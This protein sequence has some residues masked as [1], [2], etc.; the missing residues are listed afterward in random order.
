M[1]SIKKFISVKKLK[2]Y[3]LLILL[4]L[5]LGLWFYFLIP[6]KLFIVP[7]STI[8]YSKDKELMGA[9][10]ARDGQ[11]RFP[12]PDSIPYKFKQSLI[13]FEDEWFYRHPGVNPI[14]LIKALYSDIKARKII[15]GGS[16]LT[17]QLARIARHN[18]KRN[19]YQKIME[20]FWAL[21]LETRYNKEDILKLYAA[22]APF[23]GNVVGLE[24]ASWRYF[25]RSP[26]KLSW[27][28]A[29]TLAVLPN[30]PALIYPGKNH[31]YLLKKR[32]HL[33][34]KL[35]QSKIIDSMTCVL[36]KEEA[37][38][39]KPKK[40]PQKA[41]HLLEKTI[42]EGHT[43]KKLITT[44]DEN[45][46]N[47]VEQIASRHHNFLSGNHI[48]NLGILVMNTQ[49]GE[50]LSYIGNLNNPKVPN[51]QVDMVQATRSTG[52][53][54]KPFLYAW[55]L[56]DAV[57]LPRMLLSDIPTQIAGYHP[58]NFDRKY[59]GAVPADIALAK[60]LN[61]PAVRLLRKY[62]L[63]K[64]Y[65]H[66]KKTEI[67]TINKSP[68]YYGL[69][70]ILGGAEVNLWQLTASYA[71]MGRVLYHYNHGGKYS[72]NYYFSAHY[73]P[74]KNKKIIFEKSD[75]FGAG[76]IWFVFDALSKKDR[77]VEGEDWN[78]YRSSR[79]IAWKTG[80]SFGH[81]DAWCIG[82]TPQYTIG[83]WVGN[84]TGEG[85]PGLTGTQVAA[86]LMFDVFKLLPQGKWFE[87]PLE[88]ITQT[89]I[90]EESGYLAG[91]NC[92]KSTLEY[93]P[94]TGIRAKV[95]PYCK[96]I[97]LNQEGTKQV[98][99][100]CY[101]VEKIKN[102]SRFILP[103]IQAYY[104]KTFHP[105]YQSLPPWEN[106]CLNNQQK[107]LAMIY[108]KNGIEIFLPKDFNQNQQKLVMQA[109]DNNPDATIYW[110]LDHQYIGK[111]H[112]VH[113]LKKYIPPGKHHLT[114]LDD[115]GKSIDIY[116]KI[117]R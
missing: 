11:W 77:P 26:E 100:S 21:R 88:D 34:D 59:S 110:H 42:K 55:S 83:V 4:M 90:C 117:V 79:K 7:Y 66:L 116:F 93:I 50:V 5:A 38:P 16:T 89:P 37:L 54:L 9:K 53:T 51:Y 101:P 97:H 109:V 43:G 3:R 73:L 58:E 32:N 49:T 22:H 104:Y 111:T 57:I 28:E 108:P 72:E 99:S 40:L 105:E 13:S 30:A 95:C 52:S 102:V 74:N 71:D 29:A 96:I 85:R 14:S 94:K 33:L 78:I 17:M 35:Y 27:G 114:I 80:T 31:H 113:K 67:H 12:P 2:K 46:Q 75:L 62:G 92:Q 68:D 41:P 25:G 20:I 70:L 45:L 24:A 47:Q 1:I 48:N 63:T 91:P 36:A 115:T 107:N 86:P 65:D 106:H 10:I 84:A 81:R 6:Q 44:L 98:N 69:T 61:V 15:R 103:P 76:P 82:V 56:K 23:G 19:L 8:I 39:G 112:G 87:K 60:S 64:F 18:Q